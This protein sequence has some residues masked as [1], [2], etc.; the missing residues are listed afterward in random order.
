[1][2]SLPGSQG[3]ER[4]VPFPVANAVSNLAWP[5]FANVF[6]LLVDAFYLP[7]F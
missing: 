4:W 5:A 2:K 3:Q 6:L 7:A 1:M